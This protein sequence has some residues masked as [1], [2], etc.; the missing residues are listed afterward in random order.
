[1]NPRANARDMGSTPGSGRSPDLLEKEMATHPSILAWEIPGTEEPGGL[2]SMGHRG[3][4]YNSATKQQR[5]VPLRMFVCRL[6]SVHLVKLGFPGG[7]DGKESAAMQETQVQSLGWEGEGDGNPLQC[8]CLENPG[9]RGAWWAAVPG[10]AGSANAHTHP[11]GVIEFNLL[12]NRLPQGRRASSQ[13]SAKCSHN[14]ASAV[15]SQLLAPSWRPVDC[16]R[17]GTGGACAVRSLL[18]GARCPSSPCWK[19][20]ARGQ[21]LLQPT[22]GMRCYPRRISPSC[23]HG[24]MSACAKTH[25]PEL[26]DCPV[27]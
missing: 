16:P 17:L 12:R 9:D 11:S 20:S 21:L 15:S 19:P 14:S 24:C 7:S 22:A 6:L 2:Q 1:M 5:V 23:F 25:T 4:G 10:V 3:V 8:S 26:R 27:C 13:H 18:P